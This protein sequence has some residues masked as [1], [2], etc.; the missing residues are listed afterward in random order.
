[1]CA[2]IY[3][4]P[5]KRRL[6]GTFIVAKILRFHARKDLF[7]P[8]DAIDPAKLLPIARM[9]GLTYGRIVSAFGMSS[10]GLLLSPTRSP[11][12]AVRLC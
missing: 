2:Q 7:G 4:D 6:T 5:E 11:Y 1:M 9:G 10:P 3:S 12:R 8:T